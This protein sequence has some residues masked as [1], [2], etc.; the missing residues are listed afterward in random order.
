MRVSVCART[1]VILGRHHDDIFLRDAYDANPGC[2]FHRVS[3]CPPSRGV[4]LPLERTTLGSLP[5]VYISTAVGTKARSFF[6]AADT[7]AL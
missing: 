5:E 6:I 4:C 2:G 1:A 7:A 3:N